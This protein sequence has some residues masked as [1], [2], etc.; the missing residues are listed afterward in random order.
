MPQVHPTAI[1][2]GPIEL[3]EDVCVGPYC[4]LQGRIRI[5]AGTRLLH[6]VYL[7]G[8]LTLGE[9]NTVYPNASLGY[10]P[11]DRKFSPSDEGAGTVIGHENVFREGSS[12]HR[13]TKDIPTTIGDRNYFMVNTHAAHDN[14]V[15]N[16]CTLANGALLAGHVTVGD[17]VIFGGNCGIHQFT[18]IGRMVMIGG[19]AAV[20]HDVPPFCVV[21]SSKQVGS[22]NII[23]LRRGGLGGHIPPLKKAFELLYRSRLGRATAVKRILSELSIDPLCVEFAEFV[24]D[25]KR[26]ILAYGG[27]MDEVSV[28]AAATSPT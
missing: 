25:T 22:L 17:G 18:R 28:E 11:Q 7:Q 5:G 21:Y 16:D 23:G 19:A 6:H 2:D 27:N 20:T 13:A 12:V 4:C 9:R 1:L 15:G 14:R 3:A 26:G 24:R 10:A 8:P